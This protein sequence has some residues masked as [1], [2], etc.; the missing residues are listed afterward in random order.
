MN[1]FELT[2]ALVDIESVTG[3]EEKAGLFLLEYLTA[4]A[5]RSGGSVE[6]MD[7][8]PR[9]FNV[10]ASWGEPIVTL[11]THIDVVPPWFASSEDDE[12]IYG[13]GACDAKGIAAS[14]IKAAEALLDEGVRGFALLFVA[15]EE[16]N[17]AGAIAAAK[18]SRGSRFLVNGEPTENKLALGSKGALRYEIAAHGRM[19][20]SA[21]PELGE[22]A[23]LKLLDALQRL[24]A[25]ELP[26]DDILGQS[27]M[28][29]G[30]IAG[31][32]APN[33]IPD[34]ATAEIMFRL[35]AP[36]GPLR[37]EVEKAVSG[38]AEAREI[39]EIPAVRLR[40]IE[41][42]PT[43]VVSFTT[44]IPAFNG[45]WGE[46]LLIG[47]GSVHV[48]HTLDE[49]VP[50]RQLSEAAGIYADITRRLLAEAA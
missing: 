23:I 44:D 8:E 33:V 2:R 24:R 15:G 36:S 50:K 13:R 6:R 19:A 7:I 30:T 31:G 32:R 28:N 22:S 40:S 46:P 12:F 3:N 38:L 39:L 27:T 25:I 10:L 43:T 34:E 49:R 11:S 4:L 47:P 42:F 5:A 45:A 17:S 35:V 37:A 26:K 1:I 48:A 16:R 18:Q 29:I 20:H 14:M 41:G 9:R 21:Y